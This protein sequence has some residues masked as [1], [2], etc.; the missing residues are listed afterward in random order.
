[1]YTVRRVEIGKTE[2][3][4]T[5]A[6]ACGELYSQ[7]LVSFWQMVRKHSL[8]LKPKYLMRWHTSP[9]LHAYTSDAVC[10]PPLRPWTRG[11]HGLRN[12]IAARGLCCIWGLQRPPPPDRS[13]ACAFAET[14]LDRDKRACNEACPRAASCEMRISLRNPWACDP[15]NTLTLSVQCDRLLIARLPAEPLLGTP[16]DDP[17]V[18]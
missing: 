1:M 15:K 11:A 10:S 17:F 5:L 13:L 4:E 18:L 6:H 2:Q 14:P 12:E 16:R 7:T 8:W 9:L 3:L